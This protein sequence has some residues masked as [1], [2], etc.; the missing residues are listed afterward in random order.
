M[1]FLSSTELL[2]ENETSW[3]YL[4]QDYSGSGVYGNLPTPR[5][6]FSGLNVDDRVLM[7]GKFY[8]IK[9]LNKIKS[10]ILF[11]GGLY[12]YGNWDGDD[13][14]ECYYLD[15]IVEF[16]NGTGK[17]T[18]LDRMRKVKGCCGLS[19]SVREDFALSSVNFEDIE[20]YCVSDSSAL[21]LHSNLVPSVLIMFLFVY[22][23]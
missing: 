8:L 23:L 11:E 20:P 16:K 18:L 1:D 6:N 21:G 2:R 12:Y 19:C 14:D 10:N 22:M 17:W 13:L 3:L 7:F 15:E 5:S 9:Y 4:E